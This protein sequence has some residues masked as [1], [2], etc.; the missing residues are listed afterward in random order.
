MS[1]DPSDALVKVVAEKAG[2]EV[3]TILRPVANIVERLY[4]DALEPGMK[5]VGKL[6]KNSIS[7]LGAPLEWAEG[8]KAQFIADSLRRVP[9]DR[10]TEVPVALLGPVLEGA[11]YHDQGTP[12]YEMFAELLA[13]GFDEQRQGEAHPAY[14]VVLGQLSPDEARLLELTSKD[15]V[16]IQALQFRPGLSLE[17]LSSYVEDKLDDELYIARAQNDWRMLE[18]WQGHEVLHYPKQ[19]N[20]Y[21]EHLK[22]LGLVTLRHEERAILF[23]PSGP[24]TPDTFGAEQNVEG[25]YL[26]RFGRG[27]V[28]ACI[29][30][31]REWGW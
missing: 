26:T 10:R 23:P 7:L 3:G 31:T 16:E 8:K 12:L 6:V 25:L 9:E 17:Q 11:R 30:E 27:F 1:D 4:G 13:R 20:F 15:E 21:Y 28:E 18:V 5:E 24:R 29:P 2:E 14:V 19:M 22:H